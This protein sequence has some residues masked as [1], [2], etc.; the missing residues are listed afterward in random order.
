MQARTDIVLQHQELVYN[1]SLKLMNE[2]DKAENVLQ[3]TFLKVFEKLD[4][5]KGNSS[6]QT[7]IYRITTNTALMTLRQRKGT[8][9]TLEED[10]DSEQ[11]AKYQAML[12]SLDRDPLELL[13]DSEFKEAL[14]R[15]MSKLPDSW[16][17]P[18]ILKDIEGHSLKEVAET[19]NTSVPAV[20]AAL[21]RGR[22]AL[23]DHLADFIDQQKEN[24]P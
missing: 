2:A 24:S 16:R 1:L 15:A 19:L 9:I 22:S 11:K 23:R 21:H 10:P 6:L 5:F 20:K 17:I 12:R 13:M 3:D 14:E 8:V 18:F 7:W 4:T